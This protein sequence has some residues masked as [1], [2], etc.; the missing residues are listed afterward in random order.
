MSKLPVE[1]CFID[2]LLLRRNRSPAMPTTRKTPVPIK[3]EDAA[4]AHTKSHAFTQL[5]DHWDL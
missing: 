4:R 2:F 1:K 3:Q 5:W